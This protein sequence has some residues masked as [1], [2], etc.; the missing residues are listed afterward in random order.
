M[1][2]GQ[3][4]SNELVGIFNVLPRKSV[5]VWETRGTNFRDEAKK[6]L[7]FKSQG[8]IFNTVTVLMNLC[9]PRMIFHRKYASI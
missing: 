6:K 5:R 9:T 7:K 4:A 3:L 1:V 8:I 2:R